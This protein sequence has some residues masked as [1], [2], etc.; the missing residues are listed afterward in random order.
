MVGPEATSATWHVRDDEGRD[1]RRG[2][3]RREPTA[4]DGGKFL[5][6]GVHH[7]DR[8]AGDEERAVQRLLIREIH[9]WAGCG[10]QGRAP[11]GDQRD[12]EIVGGQAADGLDQPARGDLA[13]GVGH[14]MGGLQYF[15]ALTGDGITVAGDDDAR[16]RAVPGGLEGPRHLRRGLAGADNDSAARRLLRQRADNGKLRLGAGHRGMEQA[17][18]E[19]SRHLV[20]P[21]RRHTGRWLNGTVALVKRQTS[22]ATTA[23]RIQIYAAP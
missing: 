15:D 16:K 5:A 1:P 7:A 14:R 22:G 18:E 19:F 20:E 23:S 4:L 13:S 8:R 6:D 11:A 3:Q 10:E 17:F 12:D 21:G 9:A 2:G